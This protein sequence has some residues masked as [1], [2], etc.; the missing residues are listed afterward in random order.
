MSIAEQQQVLNLIKQVAA[1]RAEVTDLRERHN[2]LDVRVNLLEEVAPP[3]EIP[4][5]PAREVLSLK[6]G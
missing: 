1:L 5:P 4:P 6:R 2:S 3:V